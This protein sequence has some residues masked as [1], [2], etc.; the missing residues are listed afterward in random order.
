MKRKL[1]LALIICLGIVH[2][3]QAKHIIGGVMTYECLGNGRYEFTLK[4]YRDCNCTDCAEFDPFASIGI[5]RCTGDNCGGQNQNNPFQEVDVQ[6]LSV[7][8]VEEPDY[9][10]LIPPDVCVQEGLYQFQLD[11]PVSSTQSYH[12]SYQRC[13]R[14]VTISNIFNPDQIGATH[15]IE[16]TPLAQQQCNNSAIFNEFPPTIICAGTSLV[17]DHSAT[18]ADGDQLVYSFCAPLQGGGPITDNAALYNTCAGAQPIPACPPPYDPIVFIGPTYSPTNPVGGNPAISIDPNTGIITGTPNIQGQFV[19]GVC[20]QEF[21]NGMLI[22][23]VFRDFQFNV[24]SCDPTVI[25]QIASDELVDDE[26]V[27]ISCGDLDVNFQNTSF[28]QNFIEQYEWTFDIEGVPTTFDVWSPLVSFPDTGTYLGNLILNPNTACGDTAFIQV[29][30]YPDLDADFEFE[31]DTCIAGPVV[32]T[33]LSYAESGLITNWD[34]DFADGNTSTLQHPIHQYLIPDEFPVGLTITDINGCQDTEIKPLL[35]FPVPELLVVAPTEEVACV[36]ARILFNNLSYPISEAYDIL[37]NFGDGGTDTVVSPIYVYEETGTYTVSIDIVSPLGCQTDTTFFDLIT[38]LPSPM[39][40]FSYTPSQ[41]SNIVPEIRITDE[42]I[43]AIRWLYDFG[44]G[45]TSN[46]QEPVYVFP[47]TGLYQVMQ[48]VTHP[49]GCKDTLIQLIDV[50]PEVRFYLPNAFTP[51]Y[52]GLNDL[53]M[54]TG[55]MIGATHFRMQIWNRWGEQVFETSDLLKG[56]DGN[57]QK[58]GQ[59]APAGVYMVLV[60]YTGPRGQPY[61]IKGVATIVR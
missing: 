61:V 48:V 13:C 46:L 14:N 58:T 27:V 5:Y 25:A 51:N 26:F 45:R 29:N 20:V 7:T 24:A 59:P 31:Y 18:D 11:L 60:T 54:G 19:V 28:Q 44:S 56:W 41:P 4:L 1:E 34:W 10:C 42:S 9:P 33:D 47:D 35:Y 6:L 43:D 50:I 36:P 52:D 40:G 57:H 12:V 32:F 2:L 22:N 23:E 17:F 8:R 30:I 39:A 53:Y 38:V 16:I 3:A 15:T 37:W 21:R 55:V 49:S